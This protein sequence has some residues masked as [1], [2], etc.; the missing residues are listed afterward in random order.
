MDGLKPSQRKILYTLMKQPESRE[1]KVSQLAGLV[2]QTQAYHHGEV[3]AF[4]ICFL[5]YCN[6][7]Q[8]FLTKND[9][10]SS[11]KL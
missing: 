8:H 5:N 11:Q 2:A 9:D 1:I 10:L 7:F 3:C 6:R 4:L